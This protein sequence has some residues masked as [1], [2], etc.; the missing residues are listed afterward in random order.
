MELKV[1]QRFKV[2]SAIAGEYEKELG[3]FNFVVE[4]F[5]LKD[6]SPSPICPTTRNIHFTLVDW[7][8]NNKHSHD[9]IWF[10]CY[11]I[12]MGHDRYGDD[13]MNFSP[14]YIKGEGNWYVPDLFCWQ[15]HFLRVCQGGAV[16]PM[17]NMC[18]EDG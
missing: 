11:S 18:N 7:E 3:K 13:S 6:Y 17:N 12:G 1:G 4:I 5:S 16:T 14:D 15:H 2:T 9:K 10:A 8:P